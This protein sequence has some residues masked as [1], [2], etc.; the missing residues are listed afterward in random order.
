[1]LKALL[2]NLTGLSPEIA[3]LYKPTTDGKF[4]LQIEAV[5]GMELSNTKELKDSLTAERTE[6]AKLTADAAAFKDLDPRVARDAIAKLAEI[7]KLDPNKDADKIV[8]ARIDSVKAALTE[9]HT[10]ETAKRDQQ[11]N[12]LTGQLTTLVVD[13]AA[14]SALAENKGS[15]ALLL[16]HVRNSVKT[17]F[18]EG[19][20]V[21]E[22]V[23]TDGNPILNGK[24]E[25]ISIADHVKA[26]RDDKSFAG[27]FEGSGHSGSGKAFDR[28]GG[29]G[30]AQAGNLAGS[31][32]DQTAA[33]ANKFPHL[34]AR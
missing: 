5:D 34:P 10:A 29:G 11:I 28:G 12:D 21:A 30:G 23:G 4:V 19:K 27:A 17:K 2:A 15:V 18:I 13:N 14:T 3:A 25:P 33:V 7:E 9:A 8:Q 22:V 24:G 16:P 1:M 32:S 26:M 31:R 20:I 6:R